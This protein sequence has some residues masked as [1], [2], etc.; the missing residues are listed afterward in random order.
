MSQLQY[1]FKPPYNSM[2]T[3]CLLQHNNPPKNQLSTLQYIM[4]TS[5]K[6]NKIISITYI[7]TISIHNSKKKKKNSQY[8]FKSPYNFMQTT[9]LLQHNNPPHN[10]LSTSPYIMHTSIKNYKII[11]ITYKSTISIHNSLNK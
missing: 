7:S 3:T 1:K 9:R 2:Q 5:I 6:N 4:L 11:S 8:E 10:Q